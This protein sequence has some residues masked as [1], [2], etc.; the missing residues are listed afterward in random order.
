[1]P[2]APG[3]PVKSIHI[4]ALAGIPSPRWEGELQVRGRCPLMSVCIVGVIGLHP[5]LHNNFFLLGASAE[6]LFLLSA[7]L[8]CETTAEAFNEVLP[9]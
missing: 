7:Q 2:Q 4:Q 9:L 8:W 3:P 6:T 5:G 1:M